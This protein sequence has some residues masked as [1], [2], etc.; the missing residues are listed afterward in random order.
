[1]SDLTAIRAA[2]VQYEQEQVD[3]LVNSMRDRQQ[4]L[5]TLVDKHGAEAVAEASGLTVNTVKHYSRVRHTPNISEEA[6]IKAE[7]ILGRL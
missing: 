2:R 3:T 4:R 6:V 5:K 7:T 1:M